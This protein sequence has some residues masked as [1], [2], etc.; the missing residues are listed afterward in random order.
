[1]TNYQINVFPPDVKPD[2]QTAILTFKNRL[3]SW[4]M[5]NTI[6]SVPAAVSDLNP[7]ARWLKTIGIDQISSVRR[8]R[9][10]MNTVLRP[11]PA[12]QATVGFEITFKCGARGFICHRDMPEL[13]ALIVGTKGYLHGLAVWRKHGRIVGTPVAWFIGQRSA[14]GYQNANS[15]PRVCAAELYARA[16]GKSWGLS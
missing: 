14:R 3:V 5:V 10:T 4:Q 16:A 15:A 7:E 6:E 1:M 9:C 2:V 13:D 12:P 11:V 8:I